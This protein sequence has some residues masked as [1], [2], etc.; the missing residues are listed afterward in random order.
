[1]RTLISAERKL[2][3]LVNAYGGQVA[4][5]NMGLPIMITV[6]REEREDV[7]VRL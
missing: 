5:G 1:M 7:E 2:N 3:F 6:L 4:L